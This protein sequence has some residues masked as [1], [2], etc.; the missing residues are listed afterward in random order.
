MYSRLLTRA[1][2]DS[3][4]VNRV[5]NGVRLSIFERDERDY[6]IASRAVGEVF[7]LS[8]NICEQLSVYLKVVSALLEG[9]AVDLLALCLF[10]NII[11]VDF[12]Y[13]VVALA[14]GF[15]NFERLGLI[16][17]GDNAVGDLALYHLR[18]SNIADIGEGDPV[19][20]RT[21]SVRAACARIGAGER[22]V[23]KT[24]YV[25][26][27]AGFFELVGERDADRR[28]GGADMLKRSD[29]RETESLF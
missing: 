26:D 5:A 13:I 20:E 1:D 22:G 28:R 4:P 21:H 3:L 10:G 14:L 11:R 19:A 2:A 27:K 17:G 29:R 6:E 8:D 18:G 15:E 25:V 23:V 24:L 9:Y 7:V 16:A 12:H